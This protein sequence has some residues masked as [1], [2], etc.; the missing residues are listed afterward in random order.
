[1]KRYFL[2]A[3]LATLFIGS[4]VGCSPEEPTPP[5]TEQEPAPEGNPPTPTPPDDNNNT[6]NTPESGTQTPTIDTSIPA[7]DG[8][9]ADDAANDVVGDDAEIYWEKNTF[10]KIV[11]VTYADSTAVVETSNQDV[12]YNVTGAHVALDLKT[13]SV[14]GVEVYVKG[15]TTDGS[16]KLYGDQKIKLTLAGVDLT[17]TCGPAINNQCKK[18]LFVHLADSSTNRLKDAAAYA[19]DKYYIGGS[20]EDD[21]DRKGCFFSEG[22]MIFSGQGVIVAE[23]EKKH[24]IVTD[25]S[26][27]VRPG[28]TVVVEDAA[29]N[30]LHVK[31]DEDS[32]RGVY[33]AGGL[34]YVNVTVDAGKCIKT[35][36]DVEIAGGRLILNT[37]GDA[38][39]DED[40]ADTSSSACI[41]TDGDLI[42]KGGKLDLKSTGLGGKGFNV[43]CNLQIDGGE[44]SIATTGGKYIYDEALDLTSSPKGVKADGDIVFNDGKLNITV[45]GESDGSEGFESKAT[46]TINGGEIYIWAYDDAINAATDITINGGRVYCYAANN[47]AVDS[48]GTININGGLLIASGT[49]SPEAGVDCDSSQN[50]KITGGIVIGTGGATTSPSSAS[51]QRSVIY[52]RIS[53]TKGNKITI[54]DSSNKPILTHEFQ[55][56][57]NGMCLLV[58]C[59][60]IAQ[61]ATY[62]VHS[63]GTLTGYTDSWN[64]WF[65]GG[66]WS[67]GTQLGSF[68]SS[69]MVTTVGGSSGPG[70]RP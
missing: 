23:G 28:S 32:G 46:M 4:M 69:S 43:D 24:T 15:K 62:T 48:N 61:G 19:A 63:G 16:L 55:R 18:P 65:S 68:T 64:G 57:M 34:I 29:K 3:I 30:A 8:E 54:L 25:G 33:V 26:L 20:T 41:K 70:G 60:E 51:T 56:S 59:P 53:A 5:P 10:D 17:S 45:V 1:M 58:S 6:G 35:D 12:A 39:Y 66:T 22:N 2:L 44:I 13:K 36:L 14:S 40:D 11:V 9:K 31:G 49:S 38:I 47:D 50:F 7:Y 37:S 42:V 21:E 27:Y 52:N 67:G